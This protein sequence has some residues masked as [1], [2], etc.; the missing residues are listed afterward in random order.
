MVVGETDELVAH[1]LDH[2]VEVDH[3]L[4][5]VDLVLQR[6]AELLVLLALLQQ[7][8]YFLLLEHVIGKQALHDGL[9]AL[10]VVD[11]VDLV[12]VDRRELVDCLAQHCFFGTLSRLKE[13]LSVFPSEC[14]FAVR[15][16]H[17]HV[18]VV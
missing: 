9:F 7:V 1:N 15:V 13:E 2:H 6:Q 11:V 17:I 16:E 4:E 12:F 8:L 14:E 3:L 18:T 5:L 10:E